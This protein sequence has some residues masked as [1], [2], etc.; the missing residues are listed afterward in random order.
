MHVPHLR[1]RAQELGEREA[2]GVVRLH[3][4]RQRLGPAEHEERVERAQD[5]AFRVLYEPQ[6]LDVVSRTATTMP[7]TLSLWPLRYLV[8]LWVTRSAPNSI[9]RWMY[10][11]ANVLSTTSLALWRWARSAAARRSVMR[12]TGL[13]GVSTNSIFVAGVIA[14]STSSRFDVSTYVNES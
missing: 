7:P 10:G 14:R 4:D 2:V 1:V 13:V 9:G 3:P 12:I 11:L 8:V 5:R 6:P